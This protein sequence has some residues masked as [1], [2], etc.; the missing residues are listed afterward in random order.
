LS[1]TRFIP[2]I[3]WFIFSF[4]L[5]CLPGSNV[6]SYPWL[7]AIHADKLI[8]IGL[9]FILCRLFARPFRKTEHAE[10]QL[11]KWFLF[12]LISG[13]A[14]GTII[15]FIQ[16]YWIPG[17]SFEVWDIVADSTGCVAAYLYNMHRYTENR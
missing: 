17:R 11:K 5:L 2:A 14:Y 9:F 13:I 4:I 12:I 6:P 16:K 1:V 7:A 3:G 10:K 8:H 15:E